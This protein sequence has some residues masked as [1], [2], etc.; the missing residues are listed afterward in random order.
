MDTFWTLENIEEKAR[1]ELGAEL[2]VVADLF[3]RVVQAI[4]VQ[5]HNGD[6]QQAS[7]FTT[8]E[9]KSRVLAELP[10]SCAEVLPFFVRMV[11]NRKWHP[12]THAHEVTQLAGTFAHVVELAGGKTSTQELMDECL[13]AFN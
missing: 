10:K 3:P 8:T 13:K 4:Y 12:Q 11:W 1:A 2:S 5:M 9:Y 6:L 7:M